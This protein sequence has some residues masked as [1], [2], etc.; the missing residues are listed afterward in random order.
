MVSTERIRELFRTIDSMNAEAFAAFL[1]EDAVFQ[2]GNW[3]AV[4]GRAGAREAVAQFFGTIAG[5]AHEIIGIWQDGD[6]VT[7]RLQVTYTRRDG[8]KVGVPA[9]DILQF[10]GEQIADYRIYIDITPLYAPA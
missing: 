4:A 2:F 9:A 6:V 10:R 1:T 8:G 3:P 7:C 5:L